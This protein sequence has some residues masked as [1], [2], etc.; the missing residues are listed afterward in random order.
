MSAADS[1][2]PYY[3]TTCEAERL[4][5]FEKTAGEQNK[6][7][8]RYFRG[9]VGEAISPSQ[10]WRG[11]IDMGLIDGATP[12]TSI[13]RSITNLTGAFLEKTDEKTKG[14]YGRPELCW[15]YVGPLSEPKQLRL[16]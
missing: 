8:L 7:V 6:A 11:L 9:R 10:C 12:L 2:R 16:I 5:E 15:R 13:R 1:T 4:A 3:D 14:E